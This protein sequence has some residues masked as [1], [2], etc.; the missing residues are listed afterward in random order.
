LFREF[1]ETF[2]AVFGAR[3][4]TRGK[5]LRMLTD[6]SRSVSELAAMEGKEQNGALLGL[7]RSLVLS[8]A[9]I[10]PVIW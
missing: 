7:E 2:A 8:A 5:V 6:G 1:D 3:V 9:L 10:S 4:E